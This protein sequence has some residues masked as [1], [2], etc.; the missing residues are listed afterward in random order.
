MTITPTFAANSRFILFVDPVTGVGYG[1]K[2][3]SNIPHSLSNVT[4]EFGTIS[5]ILGDNLYQGAQ[6]T[7][8]VEHHEIHCG[9]SYELTYVNDMPNGGTTGILITVPNEAGSGQTQKLYHLKGTVETEAEC[10][11]EFFE[12]PTIT[13][14]GTAITVFN[15]NR[16]SSLVDFLSIFHTPTISVNGTRIFWKKLGSGI[17]VG[18]MSERADEFILKNNTSYYLKITNN[19]S[20][21]NYCN[22]ELNY[23]VHPGV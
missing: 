5:P 23:Y 22:V 10:T 14:N 9:D 12:T 4:D 6:L 13:S 3:T 21:D 8:P 7:M 20:T 17:K 16:N 2:Q 11:I 1:V 18:G 15:R 19:V